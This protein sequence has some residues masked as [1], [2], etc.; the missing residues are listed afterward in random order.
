MLQPGPS[1]HHLTGHLEQQPCRS[2]R[3]IIGWNMHHQ[4]LVQSPTIRQAEMTPRQPDGHQ[5][6]DPAERY[7]RAKPRH[8]DALRRR[9]VASA[10][11]RNK[12]EE[13]LQ[14]FDQVSHVVII[15]DRVDD[16][17]SDSVTMR[18]SSAN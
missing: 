17:G 2:S 5:G 10:S 8:L 13:R 6:R 11:A 7:V 16:E 9:I 12:P 14:V 4:L 3:I 1:A 18:R 15:P